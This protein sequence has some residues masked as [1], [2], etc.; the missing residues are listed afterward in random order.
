VTVNGDCLNNREITHLLSSC[1]I[2]FICIVVLIFIVV[3][4]FFIFISI[5]TYMIGLTFIFIF[6]FVL[7]DHWHHKHTEK[8]I[9][10][11]LAE[12]AGRTSGCIIGISV[13]M[14]ILR[15][16]H[17]VEPSA[18]RNDHRRRDH[19]PPKSGIW[20]WHRQLSVSTSKHEITHF[21]R[22]RN[23]TISFR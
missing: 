10:H 21:L 16:G 18:F 6:I 19:E 5:F 1:V 13:K 2:A 4:V 14:W 11:Y 7:P 9:T 23:G 15:A 3:I 22:A 8:E 20:S 12:R 17:G